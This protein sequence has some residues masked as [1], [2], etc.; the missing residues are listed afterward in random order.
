M[1]G[2]IVREDVKKYYQPNLL[3]IVLCFSL[4][5]KQHQPSYQPQK[6]SAKQANDV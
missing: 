6:L 2:E 5:T 1:S 3:A 4:T